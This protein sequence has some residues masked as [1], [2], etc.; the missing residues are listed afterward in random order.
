MSNENKENK[1]YEGV[2]LETSKRIEAYIKKLCDKKQD[3]NNTDI[4]TYID[5]YDSVDSSLY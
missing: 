1:V 3:E 5:F 2:S 4:D